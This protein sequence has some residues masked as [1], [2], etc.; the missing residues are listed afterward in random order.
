M[1]LSGLWDSPFS[2]QATTLL[3]RLRQLHP[4]RRIALSVGEP[5]A[6]QAAEPETLRERVLELRGAQR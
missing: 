2:R 5:V 3:Q 1:A 4:L 6:A